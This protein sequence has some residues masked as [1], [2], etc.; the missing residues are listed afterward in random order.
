VRSRNLRG[1]I[2]HGLFEEQ[3]ARAPDRLAITAGDARVTY[4]ELD[5]RANLIAQHLITAGVAPQSR[6]VITVERGPD[7][8]AAMLATLRSGATCICLD[9]REPPARLAAILDDAA[10]SAVVSDQQGLPDELLR[11]RTELRLG[12]LGALHSHATIAPPTAV[13]PESPAF[14]F[15]TTG[16]TGRP[17]GVVITHAARSERLTWEINAYHF[18]SEDVMLGKSSPSFA[19]IVKEVFWPL[20]TGGRIVFAEPRMQRDL[21]YLARLVEAEAI[22]VAIFVPSQLALLADTGDARQW[23]SIR[24]LLAEGEPL[25]PEVYNRFVSAFPCTLYNAYGLTEVATVAVWRPRDRRQVESV[26]IGHPAGLDLR[27]VDEGLGPVADGRSGELVVRGPGI[28]AGY[29]NQPAATAE[30]FVRDPE[31]GAVTFRTGD[32]ARRHAGGTFELLGR[33]DAQLKI[34]GFRVEPEEI[35]RVLE[36][37]PTVERALVVARRFGRHQRLV[38]YVACGDRLPPSLTEIRALASS[39]LPDYLV[40]ARFVPLAELP[41]TANGKVDRGALPDPDSAGLLSGTTYA[42]PRTETERRLAGL[43]EDVL[44]AEPVGLHDDFFELGGDSLAA[45]EIFARLPEHLATRL[46]LGE[47]ISASTVALLAERVDGQREHPGTDLVVPFRIDGSRP[48]LVI[49]HGLYGNVLCFRPLARRLGPDQPI[50]AIQA[51]GLTG[52]EAPCDRVEDLAARYL[53]ELEPSLARGPLVLAGYSFGGMV[54]WEMAHRLIADGRDVR[55]LALI[56]AVPPVLHTSLPPFLYSIPI[57]VRQSDGGTRR[58]ALDF[59]VS[60]APG[61]E[62][63]DAWALRLLSAD[64]NFAAVARGALVATR[65]Y[66][67]PR[68]RAPVALFRSDVDGSRLSHEPRHGW[69]PL[70]DGRFAIHDVCGD[71]VT[72]LSPPWVDFLADALSREIEGVAETVGERA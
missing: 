62:R 24:L 60:A 5:A 53:D 65:R 17:K 49:I 69:G 3:L 8:P 63:E 32:R 26:P 43:W 23:A 39:Q 57:C 70:V 64:A 61:S 59:F 71:H 15:Y 6:V 50:Y 45:A 66:M 46:Q 38:A 42:A 28:A 27:V 56:D 2:I 16:S 40:P 37:H 12:E 10:A 52:D 4:A 22:T 68:L 58:L 34:R 19:R 51:V 9:A 13:D 25:P 31:S 7:L 29:Y 55:L 21:P 14:I 1:R 36:R 18:T 44:G 20:L 72:M 47:L 48:P 30:R 54:A 67:P 41:L 35:E 11:G 33:L